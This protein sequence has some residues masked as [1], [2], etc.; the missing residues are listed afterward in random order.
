MGTR[1]EADECQNTEFTRRDERHNEDAE[2]TVGI[3][4]DEEPD[5]RK[6]EG[7]QGEEVVGSPGERDQSQ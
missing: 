4:V 2:R 3:Q 5:E 7:I 1:S 6:G